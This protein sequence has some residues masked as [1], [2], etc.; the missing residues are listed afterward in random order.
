MESVAWITLF[1]AGCC[2]ILATTCVKFSDGFRKAKW[3][4]GFILTMGGSIFLMSIAVKVIPI[5]SAYAVW[6]GIGA[7][8]TAAVGMIAFKE[9]KKFLRI[10]CLLLILSGVIGLRLS[11]AG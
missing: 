11:A 10:A 1:A 5:G 9:S 6:T 2:E 4:A 3:I 7:A 8:G